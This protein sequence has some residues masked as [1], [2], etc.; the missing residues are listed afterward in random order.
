MKAT[1]PNAIVTPAERDAHGPRSPRGRAGAD[2]I[3][4]PHGGRAAHAH[5]GHEGE[6]RHTDRDMMGRRHLRPERARQ[7]RDDGEDADLGEHLESHGKT[8]V[9]RHLQRDARRSVVRAVSERRDGDEGE[10][11]EARDAEGDSAP[12]RPEGG[13]AD[14]AEPER[15]KGAVAPHQQIGDRHVDH[16]RDD[17]AD[18]GRHRAAVRLQE[19]LGREERQRRGEPRRLPEEIQT[20]AQDHVRARAPPRAARASP[21][22]PPP[23][24]GPDEERRAQVRDVPLPRAPRF[25]CADRL[26]RQRLEA[27]G[28]AD[29][30]D[31]R[32]EADGST[33]PC[34]G[35][36]V[37]R[38]AA[39]RRRVDERQAPRAPSCAIAMG[40]ERRKSAPSSLSTDS[41]GRLFDGR[42]YS[43]RLRIC[44]APKP[45][46][47]VVIRHR[48]RDGSVRAAVAVRCVSR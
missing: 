38:H 2:R 44:A 46:R 30:D 42:V 48:V 32:R 1:A 18:Q 26:R 33:D 22:T 5:G 6:A 11:D 16:V 34:A 21:R 47:V 36:V 29:A 41:R 45:G 39:D 17:A 40:T 14:R 23:W 7:E 28:D 9:V 20:H 12:E 37:D 31:D 10:Q 4:H 3:R 24:R 25:A 15:A 8:E 35:E 27:S 13:Q 43:E 19:R